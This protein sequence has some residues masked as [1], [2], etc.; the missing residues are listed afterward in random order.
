MA[1]HGDNYWISSVQINLLPGINIAQAGL[2]GY[3]LCGL[4]IA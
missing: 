4:L 2:K 1:K 3:F